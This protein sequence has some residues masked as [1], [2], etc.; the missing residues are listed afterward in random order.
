MDPYLYLT[1]I[2]ASVVLILVPGPNVAI[3]VANSLA[4]GTRHGLMTVAGTSSAMVPQLALTVLGMTSLMAVLSEWFDWLRWIGVGYLVFLGLRAWMT[5]PNGGDDAQPEPPSSR[6]HFWQGLLISATNPKTLLFYAAFFPQFID[7]AA[8]A[9]PQLV[10]MAVT[11]LVVATVLDGGYAILAGRVRP[12]LA[13]PR[14]AL[15]RQRVSGTF[16]LGAGLALA[17]VRRN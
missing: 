14:S 13:G 10:T 4:H 5:S 9:L 12:L 11:F 2:L 8:T 15:I 17:L 6:A 1:F 3:I 7:P 16:L